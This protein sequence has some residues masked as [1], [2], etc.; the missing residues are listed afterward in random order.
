[1]NRGGSRARGAGSG[2]RRVAAWLCGLVFA[3]S[4]TAPA[5]EAAAPRTARMAAVA[6]DVDWRMR[7]DYIA[8][9]AML[10]A[11]EE[12]GSEVLVVQVGD[13]P[14]AAQLCVDWLDPAGE[15]ARRDCQPLHAG[16]H[17]LHF[18]S[19]DT[20][21]WPDGQYTARVSTETRMQTLGGGTAPV[22]TREVAD[23]GYR[24]GGAATAAP[25]FPTA[26]RPAPPPPMPPPADGA[27]PAPPVDDPAKPKGFPWPPPAPTSRAALDH[28]MLENADDPTLG[29]AARKLQ[30]ALESVGYVERSYYPVPGGF[31][32]VTRLEQI[33]AKGV[34]VD[35]GR[36]SMAVAPRKLF[37]PADFLRVLFTAPE[38]NYRVIAFV[39]S[40]QPFRT[41]DAAVDAHDAQDWL[42]EGLDRLPPALARQSFTDDH[43]CTALV[44][45][46]RKIAD[47]EPVANPDGATPALIQLTNSGILA[48]LAR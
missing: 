25:S 24:A 34:P 45:Q 31:A 43:G 4:A 40:D 7:P 26:A 46:F 1:M 28:A 8:E 16:E 33:D 15:S 20:R 12:A 35:P 41:T 32:L 9:V 36:W 3:W 19:P 22:L 14:A 6:A 27:G 37:S 23:V 38:G 10:R 48:A 13:A 42:D 21:G 5:Q 29:G 17:E 39:V 11:G 2:A 47:D 30:A 44:Y 18:A